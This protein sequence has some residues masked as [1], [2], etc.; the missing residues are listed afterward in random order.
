MSDDIPKQF[1]DAFGAEE[2]RL[3]NWYFNPEAWATIIEAYRDI[4]REDDMCE[5]KKNH[6]FIIAVID[7][8]AENGKFV[9]KPE[10]V[11]AENAEGAKRVAVRKVPAEYEAAIEKLDVRVCCPF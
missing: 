4:D 6:P 10:W 9:V 3:W 7:Q 11:L 1:Y 2:T 8:Q 5:S